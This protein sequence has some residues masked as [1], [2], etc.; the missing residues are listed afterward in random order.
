MVYSLF[1][2]SQIDSNT[3]EVL[4]TQSHDV[5]NPPSNVYGFG[6]VT[7]TSL[8]PPPPAPANSKPYY[9]TYNKHSDVTYD[10]PSTSRGMHSID[11]GDDEHVYD[12]AY[13]DGNTQVMTS[14]GQVPVNERSAMS[15]VDCQ[16]VECCQ[17][18]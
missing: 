8:P 2:L 16:C 4:K 15:S 1:S 14:H 9:H 13:N 10:A 17:R 11:D 12:Y 18:Y 5:H 7:S 6:H 3:I